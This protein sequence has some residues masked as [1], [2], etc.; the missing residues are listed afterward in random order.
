MNF[1]W[2]FYYKIQN[3]KKKKKHKNQN[4]YHR[5]LQKK[6][7]IIRIKNYLRNYNELK[8]NKKYMSNINP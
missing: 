6:V 2:N 7:L 3:Q 4:Q 1:Y 8:I 5:I